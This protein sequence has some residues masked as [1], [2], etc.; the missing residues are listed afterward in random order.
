MLA[1][2]CSFSCSGERDEELAIT[3]ISDRANIP[4]DGESQVTFTVYEGNADVTSQAKIMNFETGEILNSNTFSTTEPGEY[5]FYAEYNGRK[6]YE[7]RV[8][9]EQ[10]LVSQF[11]RNVCLMEFTDAGCTF[12]PDASRYID[13][14]IL[15]KMDNVYLM[16]FHEVDQWKSEQYPDLKS[17]FEIPSTPYA[18]VDMREGISLETGDRDKTKSLVQASM[19]AYPA[20]CGVSVTSTLTDNTADVSVK[21]WSEMSSNYRLAVYV[22]E[23][24]IIGEQK[25]GQLVEDKY[26][27]QYVVRKMISSSIGG[28]NLGNINSGQEASKQYAIA[29]DSSWNLEK[30]YVYALALDKN[31]YVNNMQ[32]CLLD[33]GTADYE[34]I[35]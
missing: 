20:H 23:D 17:R 26:Y 8:T 30:T 5:T 11:V 19:Q 24:G 10:V 27:H 29:V 7:T 28:D 32:V 15:Q 25:D 33:G 35:D 14:T 6:S 12:C 2:L 9:A 4:A 34:Y 31:G 13:R 1:V 21:V 3:I 22:V 18:V 16:A